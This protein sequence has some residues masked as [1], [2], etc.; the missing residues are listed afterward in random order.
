MPAPEP[1]PPLAVVGGRLCTDLVDVTDDLA[2]L[3]GE[4]FWSVVLPF[5]GRPVCARWGSVRSA[6]HWQCRQLECRIIF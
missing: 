4:G 3:D 1:P 2:A 5:E 6:S